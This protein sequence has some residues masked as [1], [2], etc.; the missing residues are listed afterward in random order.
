[1]F[2]FVLVLV[3][4]LLLYDYLRRGAEGLIILSTTATL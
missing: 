3:L 2:V 1:V 4:V